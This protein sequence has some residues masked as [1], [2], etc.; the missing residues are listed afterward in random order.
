MIKVSPLML[1]P[2]RLCSVHVGEYVF[3]DASCVPEN[4]EKIV[5]DYNMKF[6]QTH[7]P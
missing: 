5:S 4:M 6:S 2:I 7:D 3:P 1:A